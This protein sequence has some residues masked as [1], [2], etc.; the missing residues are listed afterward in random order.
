MSK[1]DFRVGRHVYRLRALPPAVRA[2]ILKYVAPAFAFASM[3]GPSLPDCL[4]QVPSAIFK[5]VMSCVVRRTALGWRYI[6]RDA[7]FLPD[8][9]SETAMAVFVRACGCVF[10]GAA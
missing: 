2:D 3:G 4:G 7:A 9:D 1:N 10:D 8:I 6:W 5:D